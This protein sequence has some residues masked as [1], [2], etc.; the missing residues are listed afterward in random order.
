MRRELCDGVMVHILVLY[1]VR[2]STCAMRACINTLDGE[3]VEGKI[4]GM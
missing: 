3:E 2:L 1:C 4:L